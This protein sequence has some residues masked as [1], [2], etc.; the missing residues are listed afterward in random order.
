MSLF[1]KRFAVIAICGLLS[2][3]KAAADV[4]YNSEWT[5][6]DGSKS[7]SVVALYDNNLLHGTIGYYS[8]S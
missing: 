2:T 4:I 5:N 1:F 3:Y 7:E 6:H 8:E